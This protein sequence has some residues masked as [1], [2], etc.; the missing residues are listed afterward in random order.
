MIELIMKVQVSHRKRRSRG[1]VTM[2]PASVR[3]LVPRS[4]TA[5]FTPAGVIA[6]IIGLVLFWISVRRAGVTEIVEA[7]RRLGSGFLLVLFLS[8]IRDVSRTIAWM[9]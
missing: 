2:M 9:V 1:P 6:A 7:I 4:R 5:R 8:F 3:S